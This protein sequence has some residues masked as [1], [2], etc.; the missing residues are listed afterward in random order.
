MGL[1]DISGTSNSFGVP[2]DRGVDDP[3]KT[4][5][6]LVEYAEDTWEVSIH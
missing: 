4:E 2:W 3:V 6:E 5:D 1:T